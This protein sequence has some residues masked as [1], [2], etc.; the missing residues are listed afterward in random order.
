MKI[1]IYRKGEKA[2]NRHY[3]L[4]RRLPILSK[5]FVSITV[6][7]GLLSMYLMAGAVS[8][9]PAA[10]PLQ[11]K[12][13]SAFL[14]DAG[15]GQVL[16]QNNPDQALPPASMAKMMTEYLVEKAVKEGRI[17]WDEIVTVN[18]N[19]SKQIGSRVFLALGDKHS[20]KELYV[21]MAVAS[22]NDATVQLAEYVGGSEEAFVKQM[23][24]TA[25]KLGMK[26]TRFINSTGL[27]R[28]DMPEAFRPATVDG[29]T[30]MS[31][32]DSAILAYTILKEVPEFLDV[33]KIPSLK[34]R[35]RDTAETPNWN[36]MI[37][38]NLNVPNFKKFA[39]PGV[40]GLK[41]G[42]TSNAGNC[43]TGTSLRNGTR[44]IAVV[45]S[46]PGGLRDGKRFLETAKLFDYGFNSFEKKTVVEGKTA[47]KDNETLPV[48]KG[49]Q[50]K[51]SVVTASDISILVPKGTAVE[52]TETTVKSSQ[53]SLVA[54]IKQ[55]D[56]VGTASYKYKD[57]ATGEDK[58]AEVDLV[59]KED[60]KKA[61]WW[62]LL[63]RAIGDFFSNLF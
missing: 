28:A 38:S 41:T 56:K 52:I 46:V 8:A 21:A 53:E 49:K 7:L 17:K 55:G 24:D 58:T 23:N 20:V 4:F 2:L 34:F 44:L 16:Y 57:P 48:K 9:A 33:A 35:E 3:P 36:W 14:M 29:E 54:P 30:L 32:R 47:I 40:D 60:V 6:L 26:N 63:F 61:S 39:Y 31:A 43:F 10:V 22:A 13:K 5:R 1:V 59:A 50:T 25:Q 37:E 62:R 19:A 45:M 15:T 27:D 42:H 12:A 18:E 51:F 11:L